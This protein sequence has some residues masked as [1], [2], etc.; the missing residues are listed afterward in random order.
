M[1]RPGNPSAVSKARMAANIKA[2]EEE[3]CRKYRVFKAIDD[4]YRK[5]DIDALLWLWGI[6]PIS[7]IACIPGI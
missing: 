1:P 5:G 4:A 6:P 2:K 7:R 3:R